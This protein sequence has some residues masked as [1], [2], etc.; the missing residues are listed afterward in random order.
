VMV[1][2]TAGLFQTPKITVGILWNAIKH[3]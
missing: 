1:V 3:G 2:V